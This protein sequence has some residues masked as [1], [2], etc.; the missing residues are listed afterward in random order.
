[1]VGFKFKIIKQDK[2][3]HS[4]I[5]KDT[6]YKGDVIVTSLFAS[7]KVCIKHQTI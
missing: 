7:K 1:M 3:E 4:V 6:F 2:T 5:I